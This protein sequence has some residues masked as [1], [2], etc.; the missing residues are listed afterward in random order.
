MTTLIHVENTLG[1]GGAIKLSED[2][3]DHRVCR[4]L[5][6]GEKVRLVVSTFKSLTLQEGAAGW[7]RRAAREAAAAFPRDLAARAG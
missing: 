5:R 3:G 2:F 6:P 4:E 1:S 7:A